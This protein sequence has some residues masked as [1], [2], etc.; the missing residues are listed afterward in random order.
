MMAK[1]ATYVVATV[2][3]TAVSA[4]AVSNRHCRA[5]ALLLLG[6]ATTFIGTAFIANRHAS[7]LRIS[8]IARSIDDGLVADCDTV[9]S[10]YRH[11]PTLKRDGY[12]RILPGSEDFDL[13]PNSIKAFNP[14]YVTIEKKP[15]GTTQPLNIGLCKN[16]FSGFHMGIRVFQI[17]PGIPTSSNRQRITPTIYFWVEET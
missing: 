9:F 8:E 16:G 1:F 13:L 14:V 5:Y 6:M 7:S 17:A 10:N 11:H 4:A 3:L 12:I 2:V 15:F